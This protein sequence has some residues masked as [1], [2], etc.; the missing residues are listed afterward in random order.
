VIVAGERDALEVARIVDATVSGEP[1][2]E[3]EYVEVRDAHE[4]SPTITVDGSV[5]IAV[6]ARVGGTRLIDNVIVRVDDS[7]VTADL[8]IVSTTATESSVSSTTPA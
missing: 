7:G 4:L 8:G 6:A 2:V 1:A 5:L 3:L